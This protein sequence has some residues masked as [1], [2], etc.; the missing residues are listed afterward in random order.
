MW[1]TLPELTVET[2]G[3]D[4]AVEEEREGGKERASGAWGP[5]T[6]KKQPWRKQ[7]SRRQTRR[8]QYLQVRERVRP[9]CLQTGP[10]PG[11]PAA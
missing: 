9:C 6:S 7:R 2:Q 5:I 1:G 10:P 3:L 8:A 11:F 4:T